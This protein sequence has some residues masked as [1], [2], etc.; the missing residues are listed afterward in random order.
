MNRS[1]S[2]LAFVLLAFVWA[3][4]DDSSSAPCDAGDSACICAVRPSDPI[5]TDAGFDGGVCGLC[6]RAAPICDVDR[7]ACVECI[8]SADCTT[9]P[10]TMCTGGDCVECLSGADCTD[11]ARPRCETGGC[12]PCEVPADCDHLPATP[13]CDTASGVCM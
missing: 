8:T 2:L 5:C 4:G 13:T 7:M 10:R 9:E 12:N 3:C 1:F 6:R 11:P